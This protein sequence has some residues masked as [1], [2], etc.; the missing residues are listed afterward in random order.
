VR[1]SVLVLAGATGV[2]LESGPQPLAL[3]LVVLL[4][5]AAG[6]FAGSEMAVV[7]ARRGRLVHLA[8]EGRRDAQTALRLLEDPPRA[9]A[10]TLV[11]TNLCGIGATSLA[12]ALAR[13]VS[14]EHGALIASLILTPVMLIGAEI[15]P[16]A[17]FRA[18]PTRYLRQ[19]AGFLRV[20]SF[21]LAPLVTLTSSATRALLSFLPI[22]PEERRPVYRREDLENLFLFG[23]VRD[24]DDVR[25]LGAETTLRMAGKALDLRRRCVHEVLSPLHADQTSRASEP[26][27]QARER[28]ESLREKHLAILDDADRVIGFVTAKRL[29]GAQDDEP[30]SHFVRPAFVLRADDSLDAALRGFR[31]ARHTIALVRGARGET[32]GVLTPE[33]VLAEIVGELRGTPRPP[34]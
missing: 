21:L 1:G 9:I 5:L 8:N 24:R 10:V 14:P 3:T 28:F 18:R 34:A 16:K 29:L 27:R 13:S 23:Q 31:A 15:L 7:S 4:L 26:V 2:F 22:P 17:L 11:G 19:M 33:D 6:L 32:L 20:S 30:I 25:R 12:T